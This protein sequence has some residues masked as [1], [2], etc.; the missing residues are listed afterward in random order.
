MSASL[1]A[2]LINAPKSDQGGYQLGNFQS[3]LSRRI[4][5][6]MTLGLGDGLFN[7]VQLLR[8]IKTPTSLLDHLD[9]R[10][11]V[12]V[13]TLEALD[14]IRVGRMDVRVSVRFYPAHGEPHLPPARYESRPEVR[15]S[16]EYALDGSA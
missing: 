11:E 15:V 16:A 7:R 10:A 2:V 1:I 4:A 12:A 9:D 13:G 5:G 8:H 3:P 14:D 6:P